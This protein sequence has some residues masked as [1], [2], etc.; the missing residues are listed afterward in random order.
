MG[1]N[2]LV[3]LYKEIHNSCVT[4]LSI[5]TKN[6]YY[7]DHTTLKKA[8]TNNDQGKPKQY[9]N[10]A[11]SHEISSYSSIDFYGKS[12]FELRMSIQNMTQHLHQLVLRETLDCHLWRGL[13]GGDSQ[14]TAFLQ[15][16]RHLHH[17]L[18][19]NTQAKSLF[20]NLLWTL[21]SYLH[22]L[23]FVAI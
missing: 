22:K 10:N 15:D 21:R 19:R 3:S 12:T 16:W 11:N 20:C 23:L 9:S 14:A 4:D 6:H 8:K 1:K 7:L 2:W 5:R 17:F 18:I 13:W